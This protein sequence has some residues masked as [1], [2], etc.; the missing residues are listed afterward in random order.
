[1]GKSFTDKEKSIIESALLEQGKTLFGTIGLRKT[2][3]E[4]LTTAANIAKGS[5]Y[6]FFESKEALYFEIFRREEKKLKGR[7]LI[8]LHSGE[9]S[10]NTF[11]EFL[12][13]AFHMIGENPIIRRMYLEDE[14]AQLKRKLPQSYLDE[15]TSED[16]SELTPLIEQWQASGKMIHRDPGIITSAIRAFFLMILHKDDLGADHFHDTAE[17]LA[18]S[19]ANQLIREDQASD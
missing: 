9:L 5:F 11:K 10:A 18:E 14:Y 3:V 19:L 15:H 2:T 1:M 17:L 7:V 4:D 13:D 8:T 12:L 6:T 16:I